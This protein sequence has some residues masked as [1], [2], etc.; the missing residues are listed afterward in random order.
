MPKQLKASQDINRALDALT[1]LK[2]SQAYLDMFDLIIAFMNY[3]ESKRPEI[4]QFDLLKDAYRSSATE[5]IAEIEAC[6][7]EAQNSLR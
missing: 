7:K 1:Q 6:L 5:L 4:V 2:Y 3:S